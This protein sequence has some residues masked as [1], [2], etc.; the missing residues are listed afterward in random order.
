M[1]ARFFILL[2][3]DM[4][5]FTFTG[6]VGGA[7]LGIPSGATCGFTFGLILMAIEAAGVRGLDFTTPFTNGLMGGLTSIVFG[8]A[9]GA[10]AFP[11]LQCVIIIHRLSDSSR[12]GFE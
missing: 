3:S 9:C 7:A 10:V 12:A 2:I 11:I 5:T 1:I 6:A 4:Y 8:M